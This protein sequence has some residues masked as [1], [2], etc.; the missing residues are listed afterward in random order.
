MSDRFEDSLHPDP[1]LQFR[2]WHEEAVRLNAPHPDAMTLATCSPDGH[3]S[4]RIVLLKHADA[5]GFVFVSNYR[6]RKGRELDVHPEGALVFHWPT[7]ERQVRIEGRIEKTSPEESDRLF[8]ARA[9]DHQLSSIA[10]PQSEVITLEELDQRYEAMGRRF[11]GGPIPRPSH[12]GGYRLRPE[13]MEFWQ[14]R[15]ARMNDRVL[16]L[17]ITDQ[18]RWERMRLAP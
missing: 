9:R 11:E 6:S 14:H 8:A 12:W 18:S 3:P 7:L 15:F 2:A 16:Y 17:W 10:S 5:D 4:A 13:R 1:F